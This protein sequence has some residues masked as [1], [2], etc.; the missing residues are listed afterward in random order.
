MTRLC[1][2]SRRSASRRQRCRRRRAGRCCAPA[3]ARRARASR[4]R[5][6]LAVERP[7]C[8]DRRRL[9][10]RL[11]R[12]SRRRR[13][14]RDRAATRG[15]RRRSPC[16]ARDALAAALRRRGL[17]AHTGPI[18]RVDRLMSP[19]E[20]RALEADGVLAV[21]MESAWLAEAADGRPLAVVRVVLDTAGAQ[22]LRP[23]HAGRRAP[24]PARPAPRGGCTR[25][26]DAASSAEVAICRERA[27]CILG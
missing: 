8:R 23:A 19:D 4:P 5:E 13:R 22:R 20:R 27:A 25:R 7:R 2:C 26:M 1:S 3:W 15:R 11:A 16:R 18:S 10:R 17:R 14:L 12:A 21:D 6:A 24:R 9:R